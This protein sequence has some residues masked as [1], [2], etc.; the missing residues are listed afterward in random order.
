MRS[1]IEKQVIQYLYTDRELSCSALSERIEK[2]VPMVMHALNQLMKRGWVC[3]TG[4]AP[5]TGGRKPLLYSLVPEA[6]YIVAVAMDQLFTRIQVL[7]WLHRPITQLETLALPLHDNE[8]ATDILVQAIHKHLHASSVNVSKILGVGIGMPGFVH[9]Q[10]G[11]NYT[12]LPTP[13]GESLR[14][15]LQ[16]QLQLPVLIDNDSSL[17]AL[18]ELRFG[19]AKNRKH[20]MVINIGWGTGL[21]MIVNGTLFRGHTGYAGEFSHIPISENKI[22]CE[23][24]KRGCLETETSLLLLAE[25]AKE[26]IRQGKVS[27]LSTLF[28]ANMHAVDAVLEAANN[29]D[30]YA[31][32]LL[33]DVGYKLGKGIAILIH[34]MNPELIVLSGRGA[35]AGK[36]LLAP[37]Q[38]ALNKYCIPRLLENT[39]IAVSKLGFEASLI[40]AANLVMEN[41]FEWN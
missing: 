31:I 5:S 38:H 34:I 3:S 36:I 15:Y 17:I 28:K 4:Y 40:G 39:E 14:A 37:V 18:A 29:G 13:N 8:Q 19:M 16:K 26:E 2:S 24:G 23:C 11:V 35:K 27:Q 10:K 7:D 32:E 1:G 9:I 12:F 25:K 6:Q 41:L 20:V 33:S 22:L 21:G 30:E